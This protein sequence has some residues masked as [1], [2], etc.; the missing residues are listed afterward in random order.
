[1]VTTD[2]KQRV[3]EAVKERKTHYGSDKKFSTALGISAAQFSRVQSGE[4]DRVLS[5]AQWISIA[6]FLDVDFGNKI[7][8]NI[9]ETLTFKAITYQLNAC[10]SKSISLLLCDKAGIG[11]TFTARYYVR[12]NANSVYIDCSQVKSKQQLIR[13]IAKEFGVNHTKK[14]GEVYK[15][16]IFYMKTLQKPL[17]ILD[18]AGDLA[19]PAFLELKA[20]WNAT[21]NLCGWYMMGA[22]GL[23][24]K[25]ESNLRNQKVGYTEMFGRYGEKFQQITPQGKDELEK[26]MMYEMTVVAKA[27]NIKMD[28]KKLYAAT[29]G[30]L[31]R[32]YIE[33]Q[34]EEISEAQTNN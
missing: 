6:R 25:I 22:D 7:K 17:V 21:E 26:F 19:Y 16:L 2:F 13:Q 14:Y 23:K 27:N 20:L 12:N 1:M 24:A 32:V 8:W 29:N 3:L 9:A 18:E 5:D 28:A 31:R 4:L 34:K 30:S 15:D 10:Q 33:S 11:K